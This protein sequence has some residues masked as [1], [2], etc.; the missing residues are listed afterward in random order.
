MLNSNVYKEQ[1][2][3]DRSI[4]DYALNGI[5]QLLEAERV[6]DDLIVK[7]SDLREY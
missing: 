5:D 3:Y 1:N 2:V 7:E 4:A 6:K